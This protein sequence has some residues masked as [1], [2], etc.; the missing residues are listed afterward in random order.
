M[1]LTMY[2]F[3]INLGLC[4]A[5]FLDKPDPLNIG[6]GVGICLGGTPEVR[7]ENKQIWRNFGLLGSIAPVP[8]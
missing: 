8:L 7:A 4:W 1:L 3:A 2:L 5:E 6:I